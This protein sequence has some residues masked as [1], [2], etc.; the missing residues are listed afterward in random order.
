[1]QI[2]RIHDNH[3]RGIAMAKNL[4]FSK[5]TYLG[6]GNCVEAVIAFE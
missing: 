3:G 1:M 4:A 2:E 6:Y 5:L